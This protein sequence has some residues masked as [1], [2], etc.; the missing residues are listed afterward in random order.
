M[1]C[2][3]GMIV[4]RPALAAN[5]TAKLDR[6]PVQMDESFHLIYEADS[7]VDDPDFSVLSKDF[8]ILNSSQSTNMRSINGNW[9]LKKTWD[10]ALMSKQ[11]GVFTI[12]P[13]PF[14]NEM[15]PALRITV[16]NSVSSTAPQKPGDPG[17]NIFIEVD[18]DVK[19]AWMRQQIIY[20]I[21]LF[22]NIPVGRPTLSQPET[23]DPDTIFFK[24]GDVNN[25]EAFRNGERYAVS[26]LKFAAFAQHSGELTFKPVL[27]EGLI[28]TGQPRSL[29][30]TFNQRGITK[31]LRSAAVTVKINPIPADQ[32]ASKWLPASQLTLVEEWSSDISQLKAGEPITRTISLIAKGL[33]AEQLPDIKTADIQGL[34]Q[35]PDQASL[36]NDHSNSGVTGTRIMKTAL[37]PSQSG[38]YTLPAMNISWWNTSTGKAEVA[39][40]PAEVLHVSGV[41]NILANP[42][43]AQ[44]PAKT[45]A[46][47]VAA[48]TTSAAANNNDVPADVWRW[49]SLALGIAWLLTIVLM[50]WLRQRQPRR[51]DKQPSLNRLARAVH[52]H[53]AANQPAETRQALI[54][55]AR[56]RWPE[57]QISNLAE[58]AQHSNAELGKA[59]RE[60][61]AALYS[62]AP[63]HWQ[64]Q[65]LV[66][67]FN[68]HKD[69]GTGD[70]GTAQSALEPLYK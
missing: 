27:F 37:I 6:N 46:P 53:A 55:W 70:S 50:F 13:I 56:A 34:K 57:A 44:A 36:S 43:A 10:L 5:I 8:D 51:T 32:D 63:E 54:D 66:A 26:E 24:L 49:L 59:I 20:T 52:K 19:Q 7:N 31:R 40:L 3:S 18:T 69:A 60:L 33:T 30:D 47:S 39:T 67:A 62:A 64:G 21:R 9:S 61:N 16:K 1:L 4:F 12:P 48:A 25:Y 11:A 15:S 28:A 65:A 58:L 29:F 35:Y 68:Q 42:P 23:D 45:V 38:D 41:A 17:A 2:L 22:S 14:G